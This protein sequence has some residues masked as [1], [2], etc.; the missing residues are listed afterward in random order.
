[1]DIHLIC[2]L[3]LLFLQKG[4]IDESKLLVQSSRY[5]NLSRNRGIKLANSGHPLLPLDVLIVPPAR[6]SLLLCASCSRQLALLCFPRVRRDDSA[7]RICW[8][9]AAVKVHDAELAAKKKAQQEQQKQKAEESKRK[10]EAEQAAAQQHGRAQQAGPSSVARRPPR[11]PRRPARGLGYM[12]GRSAAADD[13]LKPDSDG[14]FGIF[15][16]DEEDIPGGTY[17]R[18][19]YDSD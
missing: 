16:Y 8:V 6:A 2:R 11:S 3:Y 5:M 9:C 17:Y 1:M 13:R 12:K 19:M 15:G 7:E 18:D 10:R 14:K 4:Y